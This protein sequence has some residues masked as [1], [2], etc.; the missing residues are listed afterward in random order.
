MS[1][2]ILKHL[3][4]NTYY[5]PSLTNVG[6]FHQNSE[7]I[8]ID[9]GNDKD[10]ARQ[11]LNAI[12]ENGWGLKMIINT[13]SNADHIGGNAY[14]Q[15][16]TSC[17]IAATRAEA[18]FIQDP[19][20]EPSLL[21]GGFPHRDIKNKFLLAQPSTITT[22]IPSSGEIPDTG[23]RSFSLPG[24]FVDMIGVYT[25]DRV[26]FIGDC[27]FPQNIIEKYHLFFLYDIKAQLKTLETLKKM[28]ADIFVPG[29]G[30][31]VR[32]T[33]HL[34]LINTRK[35]REIVD[36]ILDICSRAVSENELV[37]ELCNFYHL[38]M[39]PNQNVLVSSTVRSYLSYMLEENML[40]YT[41]SGSNMMW[42]KRH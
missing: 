28:E 14:L 38:N 32:S 4:G 21:Y 22:I 27:V 17:K 13:H 42:K 36:R 12:E 3:K 10:A 35:I 8:L 40:E 2:L 31:P 18:A 39:D 25:P 33:D 9:S 15:G 11:I 30:G 16:K 20:L 34:V 23:L 24:H 29:H 1:R 41:F 7:A 6:L 19:I 5:F 26:F 37:N